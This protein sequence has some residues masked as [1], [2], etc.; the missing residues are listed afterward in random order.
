MM[1]V[2]RR[3]T[4]SRGTM[5]RRRMRRHGLPAL[6]L[7]GSLVLSACSP[8][9]EPSAEAA[10]AAVESTTTSTTAAPPT[11]TTTTTLPPTTTTRPST[12][13]TTSTTTSTTEVRVITITTQPPR[14]TPTTGAEQTT[15]PV[16]PPSGSKSAEAAVA[17]RIQIPG[18]DVDMT[19]Y[20]GIQMSTLDRGPGHWP[21]TAEPGQVGNMVIGGHRTSKHRVFRNI[22]Q[23]V[24]GDRIVVSD[25]DGVPYTYA[26]RET[27][28]VEP[29]DVWIVNPTPTATVTLFACHPPGSTRQRIVVFADLV[30]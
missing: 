18:I 27:K 11:T 2:M 24:P 17:G 6:A 10:E 3:G 4:A 20:E 7:V 28:I 1:V 15:E 25:V 30:G 5:M 8:D 12:T 29:T 22:D 9:V 13:T 14:V 21:G 23:L 19:M 26:V 16:A